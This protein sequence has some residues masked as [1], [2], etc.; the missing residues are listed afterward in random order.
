MQQSPL[1]IE[2]LSWHLDH[3]KCPQNFG[4]KQFGLHPRHFPSN[5][6][7]WTKTEG[8]KSL[9]VIVLKR[10]V[11]QRMAGRQPALRAVVQWIV[12][13]ARTAG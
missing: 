9:Q 4:Y 3:I 13:E 11:V 6:G 1:Q 2:M 8:M 5:A 10:H 12:V 7:P